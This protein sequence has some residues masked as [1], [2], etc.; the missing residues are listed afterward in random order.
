MITCAGALLLAFVPGLHL[1]RGGLSWLLAARWEPLTPAV[2]PLAVAAVL[3]SGSVAFLML[4][5]LARFAGW[6]VARVGLI[7]MSLMALTILL[8]TIVAMTGWVGL[9]V[10]AVATA[11]GTIPVLWGSRRLNLMGVLLVPV[12]LQLIGAG[13]VLARWVGLR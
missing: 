12:G 4:L 11:I 5:A 9:L 3:L 13:E 2:Y 10:C 1:R 6:L 7:W 8:A